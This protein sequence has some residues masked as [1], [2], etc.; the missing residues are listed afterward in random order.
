ML[1]VDT[2]SKKKIIFRLTLVTYMVSLAFVLTMHR[3]ST[4]QLQY[5]KIEL[6]WN[7]N[8]RSYITPSLFIVSFSV[9][10]ECRYTCIKCNSTKIVLRMLFCYWLCYSLLILLYTV[11]STAMCT[12]SK[13]AV[14]SLRF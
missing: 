7:S 14:A 6:S 5:F 8:S 13:M 1:D 10:F 12:C 11:S 3:T 4:I 2:S 9:L